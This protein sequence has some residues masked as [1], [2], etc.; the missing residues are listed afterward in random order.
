MY[1]NIIEFEHEPNIK[2]LSVSGLSVS[3]RIRQRVS[4]KSSGGR[5]TE[6]DS[7]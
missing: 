7:A 5:V 1:A 2:V 3:L 6:R 4:A